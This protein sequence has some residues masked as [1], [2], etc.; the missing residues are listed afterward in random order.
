MHEYTRSHTILVYVEVK[1]EKR[2]LWIE[3]V[4]EEWD[5][6]YQCD[7]IGASEPESESELD[8]PFWGQ[9]HQSKSV[10][11][12]ISVWQYVKNNWRH[13]I[14]FA[15]FKI[16]N[17]ESS[18]LER[19]KCSCVKGVNENWKLLR[20]KLIERTLYCQN[21]CHVKALILL[22][23]LETDDRWNCLRSHKWFLWKWVIM[24]NFRNELF[25]LS[26]QR[27]VGTFY[28]LI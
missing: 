8:R 17:W 18:K 14:S 27:K 3:N 16:Q 15:K 19:T 10:P 5:N 2:T 21:S 13:G 12:R 20:R 7:S 4:S 11:A 9:C 25:K 23:D 1:F 22:I 6:T 26:W 24:M 28:E